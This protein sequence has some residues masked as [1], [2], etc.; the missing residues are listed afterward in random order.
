V[1][2]DDLANE[3]LLKVNGMYLNVLRPL[4]A[5]T[6]SQTQ[7]NIVEKYNWVQNCQRKRKR[8]L[9]FFKPWR[10]PLLFVKDT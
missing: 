5:F 6:T 8:K 2:R 7:M 10:I 9:T 4:P 3:S 1:W